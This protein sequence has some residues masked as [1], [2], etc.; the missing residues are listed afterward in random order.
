[1]LKLERLRR[2]RGWSQAELSRQASLNQAT[3][4][5]IERGH[6]I[7]YPA[8]LAKLAK[9]LD[10]DPSRAAELMEVTSDND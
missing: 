10:V 8:Q 6:F 7:P 4:C 1:M 5:H 9:A 2:E 3:V